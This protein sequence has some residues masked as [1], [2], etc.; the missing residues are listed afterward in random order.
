VPH[1]YATT[2]PALLH[3]FG[4]AQMESHGDLILQLYAQARGR[5]AEYWGERYVESDTMVLTLEINRGGEEWLARQS[6]RWKAN[7]EAFA[8]GLNAASEERPELVSPEF[9]QVL[10]VEPADVMRH[11]Q[12]VAWLQFAILPE[13]GPALTEAGHGGSG[14]TAWAIAP[15][16]AAGGKSLLLV[17]PHTFWSDF[18]TYFE[19]HLVGP[20]VDFYGAA[21]A[22][23]PSP[24]LGFN[25]RLGWTHTI[26]GN[27]AADLYAL[28][29]A[30]GGYVFD[31]EVRQFQT[32]SR[33]LLV[34]QESGEVLPRPVVIR[35]SV[36]GPVVGV[37]AGK[38]VALRAAGGD[39]AGIVEQYW[40]M[41]RSRDL[42]E[43]EAALRMLQIP[44]FNVL[45]A[46]RD[47][48]ILFW[49]GGLSPVR[50]VGDWDWSGVVPGNV[51][52]TLW[53]AVHGYEDLPRIADAPSGW[54]QNAN[55]PP[56][57]ATAPSPLDA[58]KFPPYLSRGTP[59]FRARQ[60][61]GLLEADDSI[62]LEE[63]IAAKHSTVSALAES[64]VGEL[65]AAGR[66]RGDEA[67]NAPLDLLASWDLRFEADSRAAALFQELVRTDRAGLAALPDGRQTELIDLDGALEA[68][69]VAA[70]NIVGRHG[71]L[72]P[73]WGEVNRFRIDDVDFPGN[74]APDSLGVMRVMGFAPDP[75]GKGRAI[76]GD[77]FVLAVEFGKRPRA[78][79]L[80]SYGNESRPGSP[81]RTDQLEL[82]ANKRLRPIW[83]RR[84]EVR[85]NLSDRTR[86]RYPQ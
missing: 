10:P 81:H 6:E 20:D 47:G 35:K 37:V 39:R 40:A 42:R 82:L 24:A 77:S 83:L 55:D 45:Y 43:M 49:Y 27:D 53:S 26:N 69:R 1:I 4:R 60:S 12:R 30:P 64:V 13:V 63:M 14:S 23:V 34:R 25:R 19:V 7:I 2:E 8:A 31:G 59:G 44:S 74:G 79:G 46:D 51:S 52:A 85:A 3:A 38:P 75:D 65:V 5:A 71:R 36:H 67:L 73:P 61:V 33:E 18:S 80:L 41:A 15:R 54:L 86:I 22:G 16:R 68:L 17:N 78:W 66:A 70:R 28:E 9:R 21:L 48:H 72:D 62:S 11:V 84:S 57:T 76:A 29:L 50:P 56:W 58:A 32:E